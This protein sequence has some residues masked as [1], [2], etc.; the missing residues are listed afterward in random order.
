MAFVN[1]SFQH[2]ESISGSETSLAI[3]TQSLDCKQGACSPEA[4]AQQA[5]DAELRGG[6][7]AE[8]SIGLQKLATEKKICIAIRAVNRF[9]TSL[10]RAGF[11]TKDMAIKGKSS[12]IPP[13]CGFIPRNQLYGRKGLPHEKAVAF[14]AA[15]EISIRERKATAIALSLPRENLWQMNNLTIIGNWLC[16]ESPVTSGAMIGRVEGREFAFWG[17]RKPD[18]KVDIF[19]CRRNGKQFEKSDILEVMGNRNEIA[20]TAD[21]D[22]AFVAHRVETHGSEHVRPMII[23]TED[24]KLILT[25]QA[26]TRQVPVTPKAL[27]ELWPKLP[28]RESISVQE[29]FHLQANA[30]QTITEVPYSPKY[31]L[32]GNDP[33]P[34]RGLGNIT[35]FMRTLLPLLNDACGREPGREVFHHGDDAGNP[36]SVEA[37]N[38]PITLILP[39]HQELPREKPRIMIIEDRLALAQAIRIVK[40]GHFIPEVSFAWGDEVVNVRSRYYEEAQAK[41]MNKL[42][43]RGK[44]A[45]DM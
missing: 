45:P 35:P 16:D 43:N 3:D 13:L 24:D 7:L 15:N 33:P 10:I 23:G 29:L 37:D 11:S 30:A 31:P 9:A 39:D 2:L 18:G 41:L 26:V 40:D 42:K 19:T 32:D 38:Y 27:K 20:V 28:V 1:G 44:S 17:E 36:F 22:L 5:R 4:I 14:S 8:H 6:V 34:K 12:A 21:Y 25:G